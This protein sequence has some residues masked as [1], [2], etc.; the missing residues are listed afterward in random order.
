MLPSDILGPSL[1]IKPDQIWI[2]AKTIDNFSLILIVVLDCEPYI[3]YV[4]FADI[5]MNM[6]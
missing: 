6:C 4:N 2:S 5:L 3:T 1:V